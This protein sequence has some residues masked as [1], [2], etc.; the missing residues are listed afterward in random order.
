MI[1]NTWLIS[2]LILRFPQNRWGKMFLFI[3]ILELKNKACTLA[4]EPDLRQRRDADSV[5]WACQRHSFT[6]LLGHMFLS[7]SQKQEKNEHSYSF[8]WSQL[9]SQGHNS[10]IKFKNEIRFYDL[11]VPNVVCGIWENNVSLSLQLISWDRGQRQMTCSMDLKDLIYT[12]I[13]AKRMYFLL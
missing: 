1:K 10:K 11:C 2:H 13:P 3:P 4:T 12:I 9:I 6:Q 5:Y 7:T 8:Y